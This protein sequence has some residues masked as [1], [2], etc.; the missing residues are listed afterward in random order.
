[1]EN[2][3]EGLRPGKNYTVAIRT[4]IGRNSYGVAVRL[5]AV[6]SKA[7]VDQFYSLLLFFS[8]KTSDWARNYESCD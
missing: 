3:F 7:A 5:Q 4:V 1:M 2:T 8:L 6:T